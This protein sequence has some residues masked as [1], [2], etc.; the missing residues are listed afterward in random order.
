MEGR[1]DPYRFDVGSARI[2]PA[3]PIVAGCFFT[4]EITFTAGEFGSDEGS[5]ILICKRLACDME[6]PQFADPSSSGYVTAV[7][8]N[9]NVELQCS[10]LRQ[11]YFDDWRSGI[12]VTLT[13]GF[14]SPGDSI[15]VVLGD[16]SGGGP[17]I[18][19][20]TFPEK[21]HTFKLL[22]DTF[23][24]NHVYEVPNSPE[25]EVL[26]GE[27]DAIHLVYPQRPLAGER[28]D[29]AVRVVDSWG[30]P[31]RAYDG[32]IRLAG[33]GWQGLPDTISLRAE[34]EGIGRIA[35]VM[36]DGKGPFRLRAQDDRGLVCTGP[37]LVPRATGSGLPLFWGDIH[38]QTRSTVGTGTVEEYYRFARDKGLVD[39]AAWQGND[40]RVRS[41]DWAEVKR[42]TRSFNQPGRFVTLLGY[43]WSGLRSGGG[44]YNVYYKGDDGP[45]HRSSHA[46]IDDYS[47]LDTDRYPVTELWDTLRGRGDVLAVAHVGG[48]CC[49]LDLC[50]PELVLF[51]EVHSHH[52]TFEWLIEEAMERGLK[53]GFIAGSDDHTGR[54]GLVYP[55]RAVNAVATFDVK[56]GLM[57]V[58]ATD[59]SR[60]SV[61]DAMQA[62][63]AYATNGSRILL[64]VVCD[65]HVMGEE[66]TVSGAPKLDVAVHGT[67]PLLDVEVK[68]GSRTVYRYPVNEGRAKGSP[69]RIR[70][71]WSGVSQK[72]GRSKQVRWQGR[73]SL[74]NGSILKAQAFAMD[75]F[76]DVIQWVSSQRV[77]FSTRTS[78]DYDGVVLDLDL[79]EGSELTFH[80]DL[81]R[82]VLP[83]AE[84]NANPR[85]FT[86][87]LCNAQVL[88]SELAAELKDRDA[89]FSF[90]DDEAPAGCHAYWVRVC[91]LDGGQA[92]SSPIYVNLR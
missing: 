26:P 15:T 54:P 57:G 6:S 53:V 33:Q 52:G 69:R 37:P 81:L 70:V 62:R 50:D 59:L 44:D 65:G 61:W 28:F 23:N 19:A 84:I 79:R 30:N 3:D 91:Q 67:S 40:L 36:V 47:D 43:E 74:R 85:A 38:G 34:D 7:C 71:Q 77:D 45:L 20:Q 31:V 41:E 80:C 14:L 8:S 66:V 22:S 16:R 64:D 56:G 2:E 86:A 4:R 89:V 92:W 68:R 78:G 58:Y 13:M 39:I 12:V 24:L 46:S 90:A 25:L 60:E 42:E 27:A 83:V 63:R 32:E 72:S 10:A 9:P 51:A 1:V 29:V 76:D 21:R 35:G 11:A 75:Q 48:R 73:I 87:G 82:F 55:N 49:N 88:V 5:R 18:R 17:G